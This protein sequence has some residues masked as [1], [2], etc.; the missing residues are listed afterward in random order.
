MCWGYQDI[1]SACTVPGNMTVPLMEPNPNPVIVNL[2]PAV[3]ARGKISFMNGVGHDFP[4]GEPFAVE[5]G[6]SG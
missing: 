4:W 5:A 2:V 6:A 1:I 3:A